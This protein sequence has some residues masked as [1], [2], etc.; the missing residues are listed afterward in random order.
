MVL[1][2][3]IDWPSIHLENVFSYFC[4]DN[5][6]I[7]I[8][9]LCRFVHLVGDIVVIRA[10]SGL[11]LVFS[12]F[13]LLV[14]CGVLGKEMHEAAE[15][16][17]A[18]ASPAAIKGLTGDE[19]SSLLMLLKRF[20]ALDEQGRP[21]LELKALAGVEANFLVATRERLKTYLHRIG[22]CLQVVVL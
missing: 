10:V 2:L 16:A 8:N 15:K 5:V 19:A 13:H 12:S 6:E 17:A 11:M 18:F 9:I 14:F 22:L 20:R 3:E 7:F 4:R 1:V 21:A